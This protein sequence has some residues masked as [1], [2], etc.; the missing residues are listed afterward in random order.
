MADDPKRG[1]ITSDDVLDALGLAPAGPGDV[2]YLSTCTAAANALA[3]RRRQAAGYLDDPDVVPGD[4]VKLGTVLVAVGLYRNRGALAGS[5][6][7]DDVGAPAPSSGT[8]PPDVLRLLGVP[9][10]VSA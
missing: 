2:A 3:Y 9:R 8:M 10:A 1:W 4:A 6:A 5:A 7:F